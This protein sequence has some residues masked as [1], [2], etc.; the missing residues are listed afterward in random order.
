MLGF[1]LLF[2]KSLA[3]LSV[4]RFQRFIS[5]LSCTVHFFPL[6]RL[7]RYCKKKNNQNWLSYNKAMIL[8]LTQFLNLL[9][10]FA[11]TLETRQ[12]GEHVCLQI[13]YFCRTSSTVGIWTL[14]LEAAALALILLWY[15]FLFPWFKS[16]VHFLFCKSCLSSV[17]I[18][19]KHQSSQEMF[20]K[21]A[22]LV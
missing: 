1:N 9:R 6:S 7:L 17:L 10:C 12:C 21:D 19:Y 13:H 5:S 15:N 20:C 22:Y 18:G 3:F 16:F 11:L 2:N 4:E 8:L 14:Y